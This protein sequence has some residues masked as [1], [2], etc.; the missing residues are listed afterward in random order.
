MS[1]AQ[2][3]PLRISQ[4]YI[5]PLSLPPLPSFP[6]P[7]NHYLYIGIHTP[8]IPTPTAHRSLFLVN[9]PFDATETHIK[10]L[11]AGQIGLSNGRIEDV[12][13]ES[14]RQKLQN[15][16]EFQSSQASVTKK[17]KKRRHSMNDGNLN[18]IPDIGL[19]SIWDRE[20]RI[21]G[22]TSVVVFVDRASMEAAIKAVTKIRTDNKELLWGQGV[23]AAQN[24]LGSA[25]MLDT[26]S[27]HRCFTNSNRVLSTP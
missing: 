27:Y 11:F 1:S 5:L 4:Y 6:T 9:V 13:F 26:T 21:V 10:Q 24:S 14:A 25:R 17:G 7:T 20:L 18:E 23:E 8:K 19:P 16:H 3:A 2:E 15:S 22:G 12:Q